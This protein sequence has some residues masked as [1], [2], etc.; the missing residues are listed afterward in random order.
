LERVP[1]CAELIRVTAEKFAQQ[2]R[3]P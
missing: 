2:L 1:A 3:E